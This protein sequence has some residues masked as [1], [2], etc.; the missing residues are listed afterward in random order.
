[1]LIIFSLFYY[2]KTIYLIFLE[3]LKFDNKKLRKY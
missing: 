3:N 2:V 1:M